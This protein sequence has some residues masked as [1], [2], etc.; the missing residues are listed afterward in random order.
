MMDE[1]HVEQPIYRT[2]GGKRVLSENNAYPYDDEDHDMDSDDDGNLEMFDPSHK[3]SEGNFHGPAKRPQPTPVKTFNELPDVPVEA[4]EARLLLATKFGADVPVGAAN[5]MACLLLMDPICEPAAQANLRKFLGMKS[6]EQFRS[7]Q[8]PSRKTFVMSHPIAK[9]VMGESE[10]GAKAFQTWKYL[11]ATHF[12]LDDAVEDQVNA[13]VQPF[14]E[15]PAPPFSPG[16]LSGGD[17]IVLLALLAME[18]IKV[19]HE[20]EL[21]KYVDGEFKS[22]TGEMLPAKFASDPK[23]SMQYKK[24]EGSAVP[25]TGFR[26]VSVP[27]KRN[28]EGM[29][30]LLFVLPLDPDQTDLNPCLLHLAEVMRKENGLK[31][32]VEKNINFKFPNFKAELPATSI[33]DQVKA[34]GLKDVFESAEMPFE[35]CLPNAKC[36]GD[37]PPHLR[38]VLH[39]ASFSADRKGAEAKAATVATIGAY[40]SLSVPP[41]VEEFHCDRPFAVLLVDG[42]DEKTNLEFVLKV[43]GR[44]LDTSDK[45]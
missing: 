34:A 27:S 43:G 20:E 6:N 28:E 14:L 26:I 15:L 10:M 42:F 29:R 32:D 45:Q 31:W 39:L 1:D 4:N 22:A 44:S 19:Q 30:S 24:V 37:M 35:T 25:G 9:D 38:K 8:N 11:D 18:K 16:S 2:L 36:P 33:V 41:P 21:P 13:I 7:L 3:F 40:R 23:R 5:M 17:E 12:P